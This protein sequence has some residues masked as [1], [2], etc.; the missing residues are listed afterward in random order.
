MAIEAI[1]AM[2]N[3][4]KTCENSSSRRADRV[5]PCAGS[6]IGSGTWICRTCHQLAIEPA[7]PIR[8]NIW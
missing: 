4:P 3:V 2:L 1:V 7:L 6:G 5:A 8:N